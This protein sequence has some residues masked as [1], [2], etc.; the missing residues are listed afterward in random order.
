MRQRR[1]RKLNLLAVGAS[2]LGHKS[3]SAASDCSC[4]RILS[5]IDSVS[6]QTNLEDFRF[7]L[8][9]I[10]GAISSKGGMSALL[11][12]IS[13]LGFLSTVLTGGL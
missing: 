2:L 5:I 7:E 10:L 4:I 9:V 3:T 13:L 11:I 6:E 8:K 1:C 12:L